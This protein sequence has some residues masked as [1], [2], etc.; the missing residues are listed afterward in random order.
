MKSLFK[1]TLIVMIMAV[2]S[3][4][5]GFFRDILIANNFGASNYTDAYKTATSIPETIFMIV[6]LAI[7]TSFLPML[8]KVKVKKGTDEMH[9]FANN[10]INILVVI[11]F[12]IFIV[13]SFFP[14]EIVKLLANGL[15]EETLKLA[16][17]LAR[18]SLLN[19]IFLTIN[20]CFT[21]LL[22][23]HEDFVVPSILGLFFNL[24]IIIYLLLFKSYNVH[25]LMIANVIGNFFRVAVQVPSL[26]SHGYRYKFFINFKDEKVKA[27]LIL[28]IPVV[29]GAGANSL[30]MIVDK[31]IASSL[32]E[33]AITTLDNAQ[34]LITFIN[35]IITTSIST[36]V[37]PILANRRN[38][39]KNKEFL[40][41]L[42]KSIVFLAI[43]L[44]PISM[45]VIL[46]REE[47]ITIVY[48]RGMYSESAVS[49]TVM[50]LTG[51][52]IGIFFTGVRDILNS[53]L[54]SM[55]KT[56]ITAKN[57]VIGVI[58]NIA[59]SLTLSKKFGILGI[60]VAS[61]IA[62]MVTSILLLINITK[63]VGE[64]KVKPLMLK[65]TKIVISS[66]IM[67]LVIILTKGFIDSMPIILFVIVGTIIGIIT[68]FIMTLILKIEEVKE[69]VNLFKNKEIK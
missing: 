24:P 15:D 8:S 21:A 27:I 65:L 48:K 62:M 57:G 11:S 45:G 68:Y 37:Y 38:E 39:G 36:V 20:A 3:R 66:A 1:S 26:R 41:I 7:S 16:S 33:G 47:I 59:L 51:Y 69:I 67:S 60:T 4:F 64:F 32:G 61:S 42:S 29:I 13:A 30:N 54:F 9:K 6:G 53:I 56:K 5:I 50:A 58:I 40:D 46:F 28:I 43:L 2:I 19:I 23:V 17:E 31:R 52:A 10:I 12:I 14:K 25:G 63:L 49:L 35:T 55:G 34:L 22:Q 44:I 18:I